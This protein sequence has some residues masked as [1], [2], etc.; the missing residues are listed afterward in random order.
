MELGL[1]LG[2]GLAY[3][4]KG[5]GS[6]HEGHCPVEVHARPPLRPLQPAHYAQGE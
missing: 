3:L 5:R 6:G 1:G 4:H 2:L